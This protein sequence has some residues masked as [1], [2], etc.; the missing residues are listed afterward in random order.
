MVLYING[1]ALSEL[2]ETKLDFEERYL[3]IFLNFFSL[4]PVDVPPH[5]FIRSAVVKITTTPN[6]LSGTKLDK[7]VSLSLY[8]DDLKPLHKYEKS[9]NFVG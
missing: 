2:N 3:P 7:P 6:T 9:E 5:K 1:L 4:E 8:Y